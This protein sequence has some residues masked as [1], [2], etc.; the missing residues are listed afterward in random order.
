MFSIKRTVS[1]LIVALFS[2]AAVYAADDR[3]SEIVIKGNKLTDTS[4]IMLVI[5]SKTGEALSA[6]K[7]NQDVKAIYKMGRFQDVNSGFTRTD[8]GV[9]LKY[10]VMER[11]IVREIRITGNKEISVDKIREAIEL[12]TN[13]IYSAK[14]LASSV[15]KVKK[16][17]T[18]EGFF[19][20]D[21]AAAPEK[22]AGN[23]LTVVFKIT[24]GS[25]ILIKTITFE[26]NK[27][28]S[29]RELRGMM[30][31][32]E[33]WFL[34]WI[35]GAGA[36]KEDALKND[37]NIIADK[38]FNKGYVNVKI[39][40]PKV[41]LLND[42]S[43][44]QVTIPISE[45]E[46]FK[47]G[48]IDFKG[49]ILDGK[50]IL[51][52]KV[53][54]KTGEI[55]SRGILRD[56]VF[57]LTDMYADK[58]FAF[59]NVTPLSKID[60]EKKIVDITFDMEKGNKIYIERINIGG[61]TKTRDKVIR[62]EFKIG[63]G[64]LYNSTAIKKTKQ[65]LTNLG[66]FEEVNIAQAKGS[67]D[68]K[69]ILNTEVKEKSTGTFSIGGGFSSVD[70]IIGQASIQQANFLGLGLK[71]NL[72]GSLGGKTQTYT[73]GLTDPYFLD[74]K[75][76]FG[77]DIYR[78]ERDYIDFTKQVTGGDIK[79]GYPI[80]DDLSTFWIYK[81]EVKNNYNL[82]QALK[83]NPSIM[84]ES[85]GSTSSIS[86]QLS[87]NNTDYRLDP[88]SGTVSTI[89]LEYA[90]LGGNNRYARYIAES[91]VFFPMKWNNVIS[92]RGTLGYIQN[93]GKE[94]PIDEKFY[95]GGINTLRGFAAR[96]VS[97]RVSATTPVIDPATGST[98]NSITYAYV[99]GDKEFVFNAEYVFPIIKEA[100]LKA[101]FF[102]DAGN[103]YA[104]NQSFF[105]STLCSYG[106]GL[107]WYSPMGPL[108]L[109][110]GIP[111]NPRPGIDNKS[112]KFEFSI[113]GFF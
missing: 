108:R 6:E 105:S 62:R 41:E 74:S 109:E 97:P 89:S 94:I 82:S 85:K 17:Y 40:E 36:Y 13:T 69:L 53:K 73:L 30:Q 54:L 107:R 102:F 21:V 29:A 25:K 52:R 92:L 37:V 47:A 101:L 61:N 81:Y 104:P 70:G 7:V 9:V 35:T 23:E 46:Q 14:E 51:A 44:L 79:A 88:S 26:G 24:E 110:Y 100:G 96:T 15:K 49:D 57:A 5:K 27:I 11:P 86:A 112:G 19:L 106:L 98:T 34:S 48:T 43:G 4:A 8:K 75:W 31:T 93:L 77:G 72:S 33:K 99:G 3:I 38:Y 50:E 76:T 63:E 71:G 103:S 2:T 16:L 66:F 111:V 32:K 87:L 84:T 64:S 42:K 55:F 68:N 80:N 18:D 60:Q 113:G 91:A 83:L 28:F 45:G 56:D 67:D 12:K 22:L 78:T 58:G 20:V 1:F 90:G 95:L 59:A 39:G 65:N 10:L